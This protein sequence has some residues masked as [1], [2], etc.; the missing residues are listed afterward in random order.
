MVK[1][2]EYS[3]LACAVIEDGGRVLFL[4][5]VDGQRELLE[6]P[7]VL[8]EKG[9]DPVSGLR[10]AVLAQAGIDAQVGGIVLEGR[11]NAGSRKRKK[12]IPALGFRVSAKSL[13]TREKV[14]WIPLEDA[15]KEKLGRKAE[16]IRALPG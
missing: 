3:A 11:H 4:K 9:M 12:W 5:R 8:V 15:K 6:F 1:A 14:R 13:S 2:P 16:W 10:A 7:C